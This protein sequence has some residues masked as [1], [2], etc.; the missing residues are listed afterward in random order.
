MR[1]FFPTEIIE[2]IIDFDPY[3]REIFTKSVLPSLSSKS[4]WKCQ[5][6]M[7]CF[8]FMDSLESRNNHHSTNEPESIVDF[9]CVTC[10]L[11]GTEACAISYMRCYSWWD[12]LQNRSNNDSFSKMKEHSKDWD[13][14]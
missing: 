14:Y 9:P 12:R 6:A 3:W 5:R 10:W 4:D 2:K 11:Y 7:M 8:D 1:Q 13:G